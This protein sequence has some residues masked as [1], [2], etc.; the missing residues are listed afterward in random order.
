MFVT[1]IM[2]MTKTNLNDQIT[3]I[4]ELFEVQFNRVGFCPPH[5]MLINDTGQVA[6]LEPSGFETEYDKDWA[7]WL[8]SRIA[9]EWRSVAILFLNE[10]WVV[11]AK[12]GEAI[13]PDVRPSE[14][15]DRMEVV[16]VSVETY[17]G[18]ILYMWPIH[19]EGGRAWL[20]ERESF[21]N[22]TGRFA[23]LLVSPAERN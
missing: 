14:H 22:C 8:T 4:L 9:T 16:N 2:G 18:N 13:D 17:S 6:I 3:K 5:F 12:P 23:D 19:R 11:K 7:A 15:P 21:P 20:G 1:G 10:A